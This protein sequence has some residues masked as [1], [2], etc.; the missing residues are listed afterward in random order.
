MIVAAVSVGVA[1]CF[2]ILIA[3]IYRKVQRAARLYANRLSNGFTT[4]DLSLLFD[5]KK[6][7]CELKCR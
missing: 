5:G 2:D 1:K 4:K 3:V 6:S 7:K